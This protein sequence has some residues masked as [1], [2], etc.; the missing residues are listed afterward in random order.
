[1]YRVKRLYLLLG[2]LAVVCAATFAVLRLEERREQIEVSGETVLEIDPDSVQALSWDYDGDTLAFHRDQAWL[3]DGDEA[4]PVDG[5]QIQTLLEQFQ[6]LRAAFVIQD[7]EDYGQYGLDDPVCTIRLTAGDQSYEIL[8][9]D[10]SQMDAQRYLSIGDGNVYLAVSDPLEG[11]DAALSDLI[12]HDHIPAL[13]QVTGLTFTGAEDYAV[14]YAED[15]AHTYRAEDVYF[16][17]RDGKDLPLDTDRVDDYLDAIRY[18]DLTDYVTYNATQEELESYGLQSPQLTV[19]VD[20]TGEDGEG[21]TVSDTFVLHISRDPR[22]AGREEP[23]DGGEDA[24]REEEITAYARVGDS[25]IVYR[26]SGD[27]YTALLAAS[28]DDLRHPEVLPADFADMAQLDISLDGADY[29]IA[30]EGSGADRI[31]RYQGRELDVADLQSAIQSLEADAFTGEHPSGQE[32]ISLTV[33]LDREGSP[34]FQAAF[35]RYDGSSC[36]AV[37]D[38]EPVAFIPRAQVV[39]LM[40]AVRAIVLD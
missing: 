25:P 17:R 2:V 24:G 14:F 37:V 30:T 10:Y 28:Y 39:A 26:I 15:S 7:V 20:Y 38:G 23:E 21:G 6:P 34:Q 22:E 13:D 3:Y 19:A 32:E 31:Y 27:D 33:R 16:T 18:L 1:M 35:Y 12:A 8:L 4:F 5:E 9:G 29:T 40:E 11:F 36:L